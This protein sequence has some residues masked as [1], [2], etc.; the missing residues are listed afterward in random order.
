M[1]PQQIEVRNTRRSDI[2]Q[3]LELQERVYPGIPGWRAE[4]LEKHLDAFPSGQVVACAAGRVVGMASSLIVHW[5]DWGLRHT[6]KEVTGNG[7]FET[8][9]PTG[10]TLYG[11]EV[12]SDPSFRRLGI[13]KKLY[14]ARRQICRALYLRRIMACG[15][16][17]NYHRVAREMPPEEYAMRVIWGDLK[18]P[19]L[20][21]QLRE[22]F[23]YC[24][25]IHGYLPS[26]AESRGN[27][28]IIVWLNGR[29]DPSQPT[30]PSQGPIL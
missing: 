20:L 14:Q 3:I 5:D 4:Q 25:V 10:R 16:M 13:G 26:D 11:A 28:T 24:G 12:F 1:T 19:V 7:T 27:A 17:P 2:P 18:D 23:H 30:K 9:S 21:F 29:Y 8:H 6:W 15:R 22:G